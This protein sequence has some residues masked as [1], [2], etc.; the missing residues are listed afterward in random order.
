M[1]P[2]SEG[3][4]LAMLGLIVQRQDGSSCG[5]LGVALWCGIH[6]AKFARFTLF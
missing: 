1:C 4:P 5:A 6:A 3:P 2:S